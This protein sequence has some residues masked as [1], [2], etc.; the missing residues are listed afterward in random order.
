MPEET[1]L[2]KRKILSNKLDKNK[3]YFNRTKHKPNNI[4]RGVNNIKVNLNSMSVSKVNIAAN[5]NYSHNDLNYH[6]NNV[7]KE[8]L[9]FKV[10]DNYQKILDYEPV[11]TKKCPVLHKNIEPIYNVILQTAELTRNKQ[12]EVI[13]YLNYIKFG[14]IVFD[15][16]GLDAKGIRDKCG[17]RYAD[18]N[19]KKEAGFLAREAKRGGKQI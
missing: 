8:N 13:V 4:N 12:R 2:Q 6:S 18:Y 17:P 19:I 16:T 7:A 15:I 10:N 1:L 3:V 5:K 11:N 9:Y 14:H